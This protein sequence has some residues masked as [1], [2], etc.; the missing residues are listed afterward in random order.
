MMKL[1]FLIYLLTKINYIFCY[2]ENSN[3]KKEPLYIYEKFNSN[4]DFI[5]PKKNYEKMYL[6]C[7][8]TT[9]IVKKDENICIK[10]CNNFQKA[11]VKKG[12]S[13]ELLFEV[14]FEFILDGRMKFINLFNIYHNTSSFET[15]YVQHN[16]SNLITEAK[17]YN[18]RPNF[19]KGREDFYKNIKMKELYSK[20][21]QEKIFKNIFNVSENFLAKGHLAPDGDFIY[22]NQ[23]RATYFFAN[24]A[25]QWQKIN[26]GNWLKLENYVR[27]FASTK[28]VT[29]NIITGTMGNFKL[30]G[31]VFNL[32]NS[33]DSDNSKKSMK[34][35]IP[36][37]FY[38][39]ISYKNECI[40]AICSNNPFIELS[41]ICKNVSKEN[42]WPDYWNETKKGD[43]YFCELNNFESF[44]T[45]NFSNIINCSKNLQGLE[46]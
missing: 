13:N 21:N 35:K 4:L 22:I 27:K 20:V 32:Y 37:H 16:V 14:G 1:F 2:C 42:K 44:Y 18:E 15:L 39:I 24:C 23:Q 43:L 31:T 30:N 33:D 36:S 41:K 25:P 10:E 6:V 3:V 11:V 8:K 28:N 9:T 38:K 7:D 29:L 46:N 12:T 26:S 17:K 19:E 40:V 45:N 5:S 34:I